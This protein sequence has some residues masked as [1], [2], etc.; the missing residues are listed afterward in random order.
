MGLDF[1]LCEFRL[2]GACVSLFILA[3]CLNHGLQQL[4]S[5]DKGPSAPR[6][7]N[8]PKATRLT[9]S[10]APGWDVAIPNTVL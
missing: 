2:P 5:G 3:I 4:Q 8:D 9:P 1:S 7:C 6:L 10:R